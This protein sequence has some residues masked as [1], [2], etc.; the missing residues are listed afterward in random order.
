MS[1]TKLDLVA[2]QGGTFSLPAPKRYRVASGTTA[3]INPGEPVA[4]DLGAQYVAS[5]A[6][7]KPVVATDFLAGIAVSTSTETS[8]ADGYVDVLDVWD[9]QAIWLISPNVAATWD[10]QAEYNVL[11]GDRVLMDKTSSTYTLLAT[12]GANNG[13]VVEDL[14]IA[15]YPNKVRIS[16][17]KALNYAA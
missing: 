6:I 7:N 4:K 9:S 3:S 17:R 8:T 11:V 16:F 10:T 1:T 2:Y 14:D 15:R 12:D 5:M 13:C